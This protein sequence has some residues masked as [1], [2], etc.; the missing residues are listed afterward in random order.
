MFKTTSAGDHFHY[1]FRKES[2]RFIENKLQSSFLVFSNFSRIKSAKN[3]FDNKIL[4]LV[5]LEKKS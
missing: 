2:F 1:I 3:F 5:F 4:K